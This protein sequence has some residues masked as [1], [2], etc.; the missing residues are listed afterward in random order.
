MHSGVTQS[1]CLHNIS[2]IPEGMGQTAIVAAVVAA[3]AAGWKCFVIILQENWQ[4]CLPAWTQCLHRTA[5]SRHAEILFET[6]LSGKPH[7]YSE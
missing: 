3:V 2:Q 6:Q 7:T 1:P 5:H 4:H